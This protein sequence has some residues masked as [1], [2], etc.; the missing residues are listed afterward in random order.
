MYEEYKLT[1]AYTVCWFC[2]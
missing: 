2:K 1:V